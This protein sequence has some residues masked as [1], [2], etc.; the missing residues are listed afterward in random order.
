MEKVYQD[1]FIIIN[2]SHKIICD[3]YHSEYFVE[4]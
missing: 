3:N 4:L 2:V 1:G